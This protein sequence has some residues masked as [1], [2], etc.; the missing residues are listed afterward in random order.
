MKIKWQAKMS[1]LNLIQSF[2]HRCIPKN[3]KAWVLLVLMDKINQDKKW[4]KGS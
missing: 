1:R 2:Q 4:I 3:L